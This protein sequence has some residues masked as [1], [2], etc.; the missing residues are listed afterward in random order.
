MQSFYADIF[1]SVVGGLRISEQDT[2]TDLTIAAALVSSLKDKPIDD[3]T[4]FIGELTLSGEV[5]TVPNGESRL[6]EASRHGFNKIYAAKSLAAQIKDKSIKS[7]IIPITN[8]R[9]LMNEFR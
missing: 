1:V 7:K 9:E 4:C 8:I 6:E 5:K 3:K 2:S